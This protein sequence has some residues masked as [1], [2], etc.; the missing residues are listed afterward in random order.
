M[1][2]LI[3]AGRVS[4]CRK[5]CATSY[6]AG[7]RVPSTAADAVAALLTIMCCVEALLVMS[8]AMSFQ[9]AAVFA[10]RAHANAARL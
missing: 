7:C 8:S 10:L 9:H 2:L 3:A 1:L 6:E 5:D 4:A